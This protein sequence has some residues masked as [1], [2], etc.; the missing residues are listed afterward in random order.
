[1]AREDEGWLFGWHFDVSMEMKKYRSEL[2]DSNDHESDEGKTFGPE[3]R[4]RWY[5]RLCSLR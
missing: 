4:G 2:S 5:V 1:M 3:G